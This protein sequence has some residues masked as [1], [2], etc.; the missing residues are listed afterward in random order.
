[1]SRI[2]SA[3][4]NSSIY[5]V[6]CVLLPCL[7][8]QIITIK[9]IDL[10]EKTNLVLHLILV[11]VFLIYIYLTLSVVGMGTVWDIGQ[12]AGIIRIDEINLIPFRSDGIMTYI[13]NI[14]MFMP[15]GFLLPL[16][17]E[18]FRNSIRVLH[19]GL[20]FSLSIEIC[21][22]FNARATDVDDLI[23][24]T[25]GAILGYFV[26]IGISNLFKH[27]DNNQ[28]KTIDYT[29]K[30]TLSISKNEANIYLILSVLGEFFLYNW[31]LLS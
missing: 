1:M 15:L 14:F 8:Y 3:L 6:L 22:L 2:Y 11:Y 27:R 19:T 28:N 12:H 5:S 31:T 26:W 18:S 4:Y 29:K 25:L 16:I 20:L 24:N 17:W 21:Q 13:L 7:I 9:R 10:K 30:K 23:M